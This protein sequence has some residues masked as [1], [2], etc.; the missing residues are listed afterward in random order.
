MHGQ[1]AL[2]RDGHS[3]LPGIAVDGFALRAQTDRLWLWAPS[4]VDAGALRSARS[5]PV[6][7]SS[8]RRST[9]VS[10]G[11]LA[12]YCLP[13][14]PLLGGSRCVG[15]SRQ[16][17]AGSLHRPVLHRASEQDPMTG[18]MRPTQSQGTTRPRCS[19]LRRHTMRRS[20]LRPTHPRHTRI[21]LRQLHTMRHRSLSGCLLPALAAAASIA[22]GTVSTALMRAT[23]DPMWDPSGDPRSRPS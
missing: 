8:L 17:F 4:L 5:R 15:S 2:R 7:L 11:T 16:S 22:I 13:T 9:G 20:L 14:Y 10:S 18:T 12:L 6:T 1:V 21:G 3:P 23:N 19:I